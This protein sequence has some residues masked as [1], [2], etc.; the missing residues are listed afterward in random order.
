MGAQRIA[1]GILLGL[2]LAPRAPAQKL[3][4]RN[5]P[6][7]DPVN[8]PYT[9]GDPE[10]LAAIGVLSL[11]GFAFGAAPSTQSLDEHF[12]D[13]QVRW[14]E[15]DHFRIG[16]G[17]GP[18]KVQMEERDKLR[19]ELEAL[20]PVLP[21]VNPKA[22]VI[23]PWLRAYLWAQRAEKMWD[24]MLALLRVQESD[25]PDGSSEG[26]DTT[27]K[28]M[29]EGPYLGEKGKFEVLF[30]PSEAASTEYLRKYFGLVTKLSQRWNILE[31]DTLHMVIHTGAPHLRTDL[32][33]HAHFVFNQSQ[34][35]LDAYKHYSYELPVWVK[36][37]L[38]HVLERRISPKYNTFDSGEGATAD[39]TN[40]ENWEPAVRRLVSRGE[41]VGMARMVSLKGYA[42][43][44]LPH[45]YCCWSMVDYLMREHPDFLPLLL[46]RLKGLVNESFIGDGSSMWDVHREAFREGLSMTY[47]QFDEAWM[48]WVLANYSAQ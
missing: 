4:D 31:R 41:A 25:F 22:R 10:R 39:M 17:L 35:M 34:Q 27:G 26:W 8:C 9:G 7:N 13:H 20:A 6:E 46:D 3:I 23:D 44:T 38:A 12:G 18:Y 11:G 36:E 24:E 43:L 21:G 47:A 2:V 48:A 29:G 28:Y 5:K 33:L 40:K 37:G 45:H 32:A 1:L 16:Y 30:V 42:E 14:V 19:A 15:T